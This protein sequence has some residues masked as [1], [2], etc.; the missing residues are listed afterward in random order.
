[1]KKSFT[2]IELLVVIA[3]LGLISSIILVSL[4]GTKEKAKIARSLQFE[5]SLDH[6][7][8]DEIVGEWKFEELE[9]ETCEGTGYS[10]CDTS[11]VGNDDGSFYCAAGISRSPDPP[12][13]IEGLGQA[14]YF[15]N[16]NDG[17]IQVRDIDTQDALEEI[18]QEN[19]ATIGAWVRWE[20]ADNSKYISV[21]CS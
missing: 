18:P 19:S 6:A 1:M 9:G 14:L 10:F 13:K 4:K 5:A 20:G 3:V 21:R 15:S 11:G 8:R 7:L 16:S 2:V 17:S 12:N